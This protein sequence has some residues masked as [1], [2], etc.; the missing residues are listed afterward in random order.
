MTSLKCEVDPVFSQVTMTYCLC[1]GYFESYSVI[2]YFEKKIN[3]K[4]KKLWGPPIIETREGIRVGDFFISNQ[5]Q[6]ASGVWLQPNG[7]DAGDSGHAGP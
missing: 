4:E 6:H 2:S 1:V 3:K 5:R 7:G